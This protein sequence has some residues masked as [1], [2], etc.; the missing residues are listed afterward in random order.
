MQLR[1]FAGV[2]L[3]G[4]VGFA[5]L[6]LAAIGGCASIEVGLGLRMRLDKVPV[7][8]ISATLSPDPGL[9]PGKSGR[10]HHYRYDQRCQAVGHGWGWSRQG[11][12]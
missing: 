2:V 4:R 6:G 9:S 12:L 10:P 3:I 7:T 8:A 1:S 5:F 11:A